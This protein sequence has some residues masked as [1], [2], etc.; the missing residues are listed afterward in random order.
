VGADMIGFL[1]TGPRKINDRAV[2]KA[3]RWLWQ[4][5]KC[6]R[7]VCSACDGDIGADVDDVCPHCGHDVVAL[8]ELKSEAEVVEYVRKL[9][10]DWPPDFRDV[11]SRQDP[12]RD[13]D[14]LVFAGDMSYG[15]EPDGG[16]YQLLKTILGLGIADALG[17]R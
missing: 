14:L 16:G 6:G 7:R 15:D 17:I 11:A 10:S 9:V 8:P 13:T 4:T 3:A 5:I 1:V 12:E 2:R